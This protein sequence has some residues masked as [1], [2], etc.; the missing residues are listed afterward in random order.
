MIEGPV[1]QDPVIEGPV[2][3]DP[4]KPDPVIP[5]ALEEIGTDSEV[6]WLDKTGKLLTGKIEKTSNKTYTICC[7][8]NGTRY[9]IQKSIVKLKS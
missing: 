2:I 6:E 1:I 9:R 5:I 4:V 7:K 8:P 3:Q